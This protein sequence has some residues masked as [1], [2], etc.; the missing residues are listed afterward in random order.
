[1]DDD[2]AIE[3]QNSDSGEDEDF[4]QDDSSDVFDKG[5]SDESIDKKEGW[6]NWFTA[7]DGHEYLVHVDDSYIN[8]PFNLTGLQTHLG[9]DKFK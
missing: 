2:D 6:I 1:M 8:D 9:K 7:L 5:G 4:P 3:A